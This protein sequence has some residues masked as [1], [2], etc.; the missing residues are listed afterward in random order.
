MS[1]P[2]AN[3]ILEI[4][5]KWIDITTGYDIYILN[6]SLQ[7]YD[8]CFILDAYTYHTP[9]DQPSIIKQDVLQDLG[10]NLG[11]LVRIIL[12]GHF[13]EIDNSIDN[14]PLIHFDIFGRYLIVYRMYTSRI[15]QQILIILVIIRGHS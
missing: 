4:I 2:H 9:H 14:D 13:Q 8:F 5:P 12:G 10:G 3:V 15:I 7:G 11:I 1:R 6:N